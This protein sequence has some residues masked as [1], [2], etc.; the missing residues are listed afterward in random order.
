MFYCINAQGGG[1][2]GGGGTFL[3]LWDVA[4]DRVAFSIQLLELGRTFSD[5]LG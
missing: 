1:G 4:L 2:G 3:G 5:F